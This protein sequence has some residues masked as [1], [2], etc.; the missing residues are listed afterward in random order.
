MSRWILRSFAPAL[1]TLTVLGSGQFAG[2]IG[3]YNLPGNAWQWSGHGFSGGYH[4]PL[5]LGPIVGNSSHWPNVHRQPYAPNPYA[6]A[7][8]CGGSGGCDHEMNGANMQEPTRLM[9]SEGLEAEPVMQQ[10]ATVPA[11]AMPPE[12]SP[13]SSSLVRPVKY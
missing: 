4:A 6:C 11:G 10:P 3:Y 8:Y 5:V 2:A 9:P 7:P 1:V 12:A 13:R